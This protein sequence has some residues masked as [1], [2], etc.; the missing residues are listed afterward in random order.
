M[1]L[2]P[3]KFNFIG[4]AVNTE[5]FLSTHMHLL[6]QFSIQ[7]YVLKLRFFYA[8]FLTKN[9]HKKTKNKQTKKTTTTKKTNK[10]NKKNK[11]TKKTKKNPRKNSIVL[12]FFISPFQ[13]HYLTYSEQ[14]LVAAGFQIT[15]WTIFSDLFHG[16]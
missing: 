8:H 15:T 7:I 4:Y 10:K 16:L 1:V 14:V 3:W 12:S 6:F 5:I 11:Q 13:L 2:K 9:T